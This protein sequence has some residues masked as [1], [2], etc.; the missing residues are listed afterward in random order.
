MP[1]AVFVFVPTAVNKRSFIFTL[2]AMC[3]HWVSGGHENIVK[4]HKIGVVNFHL[5]E[6]LRLVWSGT[7]KT[8]YSHSC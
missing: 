1:S 8:E 6:W 5:K 2:F 3:S 4:T 7:Y